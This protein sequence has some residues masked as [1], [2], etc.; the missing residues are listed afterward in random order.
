MSDELIELR[1][2][3]DSFCTDWRH[4]SLGSDFLADTVF[5][6]QQSKQLA[7]AAIN[8]VLELAFRLGAKASKSWVQ[9][10]VAPGQ[11]MALALDLKVKPERASEVGAEVPFFCSD[12]VGY[13]ETQLGQNAPGIFFGLGYLVAD[14][15]AVV[16]LVL[17]NDLLQVRATLPLRTA[18][19]EGM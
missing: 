3:L 10:T 15:Q 18:A 2:G 14:I 17:E 1:Y 5:R 7:S 13:Y 16:T 8:E 19:P 9:T 4:C 11:L 6:T 12:P